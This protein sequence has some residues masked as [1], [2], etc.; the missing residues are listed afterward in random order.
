MSKIL[1]YFLDIF[2]ILIVSKICYFS[3]L[4]NATICSLLFSHWFNKRFTPRHAIVG[5]S[6]RRTRGRCVA[7][8]SCGSGKVVRAMLWRKIRNAQKMFPSCHDLLRRNC[9][10]HMRYIGCHAFR[11]QFVTYARQ[12]ARHDANYASPWRLERLRITKM[13]RLGTPYCV[14]LRDQ[15]S[16]QC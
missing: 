8:R 6:E 16:C 7:M 4:I 11:E 1:W 2:D 5:A 14:A 12:M 3:T 9:W 10:V 13:A 15:N